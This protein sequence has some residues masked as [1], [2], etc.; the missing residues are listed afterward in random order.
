MANTIRIPV[1]D[2]AYARVS[3]PEIDIGDNPYEAVEGLA[4]SLAEALQ[5]ERAKQALLSEAEADWFHINAGSG[6]GLRTAAVEPGQTLK[7]NDALEESYRFW[8]SKVPGQEA[9]KD[10]RRRFARM[11]VHTIGFELSREAAARAAAAVDFTSATMTQLAGLA[12]SRPGDIGTVRNEARLLRAELPPDDWEAFDAREQQINEAYLRGLIETNP[13]LALE[14]LRSRKGYAKGGLGIPEPL[15]EALE[16]DAARAMQAATD[17]ETAELERERIA[18]RFDTDAKLAKA[19]LE[20]VFR[21]DAYEGIRDAYK[22]DPLTA[23][24]LEAKVD[25]VHG[26]AVIRA[27]RHTNVGRALVEGSTIAWDADQL[28]SLDTHIEAV[29][30]DG[31]GGAAVNNRRV[32][33]AVIAGTVPPKMQGHIREGLRGSDPAGRIASIHMVQALETEDES[34]RLASWLPADLRAFGHR[35]T[36]LTAAGYAGTEA[37]RHLDIAKALTPDKEAARRHHFDTHIRIDDLSGTIGR[38]FNVKPAGI[39][40]D[41]METLEYRPDR[42]TAEPRTQEYRPEN[43]S[44]RWQHVVERTSSGEI[45]FLSGASPDSDPVDGPAPKFDSGHIVTKPKGRNGRLVRVRKNLTGDR[46]EDANCHGFTMADGRFW[47]NP[48]QAELILQDEFR[49][50]QEPQPGDIVVYRDEKGFAVHS[51]RVTAVT[52]VGGGTRIRVI[53]KR[54]NYDEIGIETDIDEQWPGSGDPARRYRGKRSR[55]FF[56]RRR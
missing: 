9:R 37:L 5:K 14:S 29:A 7:A 22:I 23:R 28:E 2:V 21:H 42:D 32:R 12:Y 24:D 47:I 46:R 18:M 54:G 11:R 25:T 30:N 1:P 56:Y 8:E 34:G 36:A 53:G 35:F 31:S 19:D 16:H 38:M 3:L 26:R 39:A 44:A 13:K 41:E 51:A 49:S 6:A 20:G 55:M 48:D 52:R 33:M 10:L 40:K 4:E 17:G 15:R 45:V 27:A 43:D 50:T